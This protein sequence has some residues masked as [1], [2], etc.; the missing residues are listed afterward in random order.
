MTCASFDR[1][2]SRGHWAFV[3]PG[4]DPVF[5]A[6]WSSSCQRGQGDARGVLVPEGPERQEIDASIQLNASQQALYDKVAPA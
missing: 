3:R 5:G 6:T 2:R 4:V 1:A